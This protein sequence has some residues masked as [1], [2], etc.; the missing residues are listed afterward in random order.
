EHRQ[1]DPADSDARSQTR[2]RHRAGSFAHSRSRRI[3]RTVR[4]RWYG[5][6][7]RTPRMA[8][9][10]SRCRF[11]NPWFSGTSTSS[12]T[13]PTPTTTSGIAGS[14]T[15]N[16]ATVGANSRMYANAIPVSR[17][18]EVSGSAYLG[19]ADVGVH[20]ES[21]LIVVTLS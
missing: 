16:S 1:H 3:G 11:A 2:S 19:V 17:S 9:A 15:Q 8:P 13:A 4:W 10:I 7:I 12:R 21:L 20:A 5:C 14:I 18:R 6:S